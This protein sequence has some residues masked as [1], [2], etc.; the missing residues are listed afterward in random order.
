[1]FDIEALH[2]GDGFQLQILR[3]GDRRAESGGEAV[4]RI[5]R[6]GVHRGLARKQAVARFLHDH[7]KGIAA[8]TIPDQGQ[9]KSGV[10]VFCR[11]P[12]QTRLKVI[13]AGCTE[14]IIVGIQIGFMTVALLVQIGH[15][16]RQLVRQQG[17]ILRQSEAQA[18][19]LGELRERLALGIEARGAGLQQQRTTHRIGA[20]R[21]RLRAAQDFRSR[22]IPKHG[23]Q[24]AQ[25]RGRK[26]RA[27]HHHV[28]Q[29]V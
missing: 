12:A 29:R 17:E 11:M 27:V 16:Q 23:R 20:V 9:I 4:R 8:R 10:L 2:G 26:R 24:I 3:Q 6:I 21:Q 22:K 13:T 19:I 1:M 15:P 18:A 5:G 25:G 28:D 14:L 7:R